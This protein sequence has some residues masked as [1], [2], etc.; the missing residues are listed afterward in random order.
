MRTLNLDLEKMV[1]V[2]DVSPSRNI[3]NVDLFVGI[4]LSIVIFLIIDGLLNN[5]G[6]QEGEFGL[7]K[8]LIVEKRFCLVKKA[9]EQI[10]LPRSGRGRSVTE[11]KKALNLNISSGSSSRWTGMAWLDIR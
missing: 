3:C 10:S 8:G 11:G 2:D 7:R 6:R 5:P 9:L 1:A 4:R